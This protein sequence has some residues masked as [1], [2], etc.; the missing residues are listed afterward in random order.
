MGSGDSRPSPPLLFPDQPGPPNKTRPDTLPLPHPALLQGRGHLTDPQHER[1]SPLMP[2]RCL[3][4]L[5]GTRM[6]GSDPPAFPLPPLPAPPLQGGGGEALRGAAHQEH[7][8]VPLRDGQPGHEG[9]GQPQDHRARKLPGVRR[10]RSGG[11]TWGPPAVRQCAVPG[12]PCPPWGAVPSE[13]CPAGAVA[14]GP[15][16]HGEWCQGCPVPPP[17]GRGSY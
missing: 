10:G 12:V 6:G 3:D 2:G 16:P 13:P 9:A 4:P 7:V 11:G 1:V 5:L 8:G 17:W 14:K 15:C